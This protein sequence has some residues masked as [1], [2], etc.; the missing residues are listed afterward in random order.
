MKNL[1]LKSALVLSSLLCMFNTASASHLVGG[2]IGYEY[3]GDAGGGMYSYVITLTVYNDCSPASNIPLPD[4][5]QSIAIY[6]HD[7]NGSP[8]GGGDKALFS[9]IVLSLVDSNRVLP[10]TVSGC[11]VGNTEC[12]YKGVYRDTILLPLNFNGYHIYFDDFARTGGIANLQN[13]GGTGMAFHCYIPSNLVDNSSAFFN[14]D[15][16]AFFCAGDTVSILNTATDPDGDLL[17]FSFTDPFAGMSGFGAAPDPLPWTINPVTWLNG[18]Y[19]AN[20]PF[21]PGGYAFINGS[22]GLT[23]YSV[24]TA[25]H[26]VVAVEVREFRN[27]NLIGVTRRDLQLLVINCPPND[28]PQLDPAGSNATLYTVE[29]GDNI[30]FDLDFNDINGDSLTLEASG[31]VF[32]PAFVNPIATINTPVLG[33][34]L[35]STQF[36]WQTACGQAQPLPYFF[37]VSVTDNGCPPKTVNE[38]YEITVTAPTAPTTIFGPLQV[39]ENDMVSYTTDTITGSTYNWTVTGGTITSGQGSVGIDVT[40]GPGGPGLVEVNAISQFGCASSSISLNVTILANPLAAAGNDTVICLGDS[41][42]LGGSPTGPLGATYTWTPA[43]TLDDASLANPWATPTVTTTY[44]VAVTVGGQCTGTDTVVV[45]VGAT[46]YEAGNDTTICFG[47]S[48]QLNA[49]GGGTYVWTP[50]GT[51]SDGSIGNPVATPLDTTL[52]TV[53][54]TDT[55]GCVGT[56]SVTVNVVQLPPAEAGNDT[57]IC[58][59]DGLLIGGSP[60]TTPG[61]SILWSPN[62]NIS[63]IIA[64]NPIVFAQTSP[65]VYTVTITTPEGCVSTDNI[66]IMINPLPTAD[67]G[68]A[69]PICVGDSVQLTASGGTMYS[70]APITGLSNPNIANPMA[71][72]PSTT[73]YVVTVTDANG[74]SST[75]NVLVSVNT[76]S[77]VDA[78]ADVAICINDTVP[79]GGA[80]TGPVGAT[81]SWSP[82]G[83]LNDPSLA[84][85]LANPTVTTQYF[86]TVT[87]ANTCVNIDSITI[88]VNAL[89]VVDA[90]NDVT[91]CAT[92]T[93]VLGGAPTGPAGSGYFWSPSMNLSG[94]ALSNPSAWP[95]TSPFDYVVRVTD[96]NGCVNFDTITI[97]LNT[98]P[99]ADAGTDATICVNDSTQ[100]LATG[101]TTYSWSPTAGLSNPN[102]ADPMASPA[103][104]TSYIVTVTDGNSC[105]QMDTVIVTV[106]PLP[107]VDAGADVAI[108]INDTVPLGGAPTG[109]AGSTFSW[110]PTTALDDPNIANP[111]ANPTVTTQYFVTVTDANS[112]VN[113]DSITITVNPL[114]IVDAGLDQVICFGDTVAIGGAPTGPAG[115]GYFWSPSINISGN[116]ISNPSV[117]PPSS[118]F[119]Y[120]VRVTDPN[121]CVNFDTVTITLN[122]LPIA[123]AGTDA[124]ICINDSTQLLATGGTT[125]SWTPA[126]GLSNP[127]VADPMA[128]PATTTSYIVTVTDGNNCSQMDTVIVTV[129][130]LPVV[131]AGTDAPICIND[132]IQLGGAPTGPAGSTFSWSPT[133]ALDDPNIAN[134]MANPTVT[135]QYF[136]TV[137]DANSCVNIDSITITVNPLPAADAGLDQI[138]CFNDTVAIGGAPT[139]DPT[140]TVLWDNAGSLVD[141]ATDFNPLANP[142]A[143]TQYIV[144]VTDVNG[145]VQTDTMVVT[146]NPLPIVDITQ[147]P[148]IDLCFEDTIQ[149]TA[150]GAV[151]Y[152]WTPALGLSDP[153]I[154][155]PLAFPID[156]TT[157]IVTGIDINGCVNMDTI[158]I[159][160]LD[161][162]T[163]SAGADVYLCIGFDTQLQATGGTGYVWT[164]GATLDDAN[165]ANPLASPLDT[166][167]YVVVVTDANGCVNTD[168]VTVIV[169][170]NPPID[171]GPDVA[172]CNGDSVLLGGNPSSVPGTVFTWMP[173]ADLDDPTLAN[174][175]AFPSVTTT[176]IVMAQNDTCT[177]FDTVIV[178]VN[179]LPPASAGPDA[180]FCIGDSAQL[181]A[182]GGVTFVWTP[183][184]GLSDDS[185]ANPMA[186]PADTTQYIVT[187]TD[188]VGCIGTDTMVLTMNPL[189]VVDAGPDVQVCITDSVQLNATGGDIYVW[190]PATGLDDP[191]VADP[192][193]SPADT[194]QYM[195]MVTDSNSCVNIDSMTVTVNPFPVVDAGPSVQICIGETTPLL[196]TGGDIYVWTPATGLTDPNIAN[197]DATPTDTIT[198]VVTVTDSNSCVNTDSLVVTVNPLPNAS[199]GPDAAI[200]IGDDAQLNA[201]GG[202]TYSWTP[203]ADLTD[204]N[205][206]DPIANPTVTTNYIVSVTDSNSCVQTD[207]MT[208][209]VNNL[210]NIDAG[211]D[212]DLCRGDSAQLMATGGVGYIWTPTIGMNDPNL[213]NPMVAPDTTQMYFVVSSDINGCSNIDSVTVNVF[214]MIA[215][216][217]TSVCFRDSAQLFAAGAGGLGGTTFLWSP[218]T[219]LDD[220]TSATPM[221]SPANTTLYTVTATDANG[222]TDQ[223]TV[224][225]IVID[226]PTADFLVDAEPDCDGMRLTITNNSINASSYAWT[227]G[228][229][230]SSTEENPVTVI[231]FSLNYTVVLTAFNSAGCQDT[232]TFTNSTLTFDDYFDIVVP[233]VF[234]P[235]GD[236]VNDIFE[237][238]VGSIL[239]ECTDIEIFNRWGQTVFVSSGNNILWDGYTPDGV[240]VPTGTYFFTMII[241]GIEYKGSISV[242]R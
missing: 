38:V 122:P 127:N 226:L 199:A 56:D 18:T 92:D 55:I 211:P 103:T 228:N 37:T 214:R 54:V 87:D 161:T 66:T 62:A 136:V 206:A 184:L 61:N 46:T 94:N 35:V 16:V 183:D 110:S 157:Y 48:A 125:Y 195:V 6:G 2:N 76:L 203:A 192:M 51:L 175:N 68:S 240:Q 144:T 182:S 180:Q 154:A 204:A 31:I 233:N 178:T 116:A 202:D 142:T 155:N 33:D 5:T 176:Y 42:Q 141:P 172:I 128:S 96:P 220:P 25:G 115:S 52:Y 188:A 130:P 215:G 12:I 19:N 21:G 27:G 208:L 232:A 151:T 200:C 50:A 120:I 84:N 168:S 49:S 146:V 95:S 148:A 97:S 147:G 39:C 119:D 197:P 91:I 123:D 212:V 210:P 173:A 53:T 132:T 9:E 143:T 74:C 34:S 32:D 102:V 160:V 88:T 105:S 90:G 81:Y 185:I 118:P 78:G 179:Q 163:V 101:G 229:G 131:D 235:N 67:A 69:T 1:L 73:N 75:D 57:T 170:D 126:A 138:I 153:S 166:T 59:G 156:T 13:P 225:V 100:L 99:I 58:A 107:V 218:A 150:T 241:N 36:C 65:T 238:N 137:T 129:N 86:V 224:E 121:G 158:T 29:E 205:I 139:A 124:T 93:T 7:L 106:N 3:L 82:A 239:S 79:L 187:V 194:T 223:L 17:V 135:T 134:P 149:L 236:G 60:T 47:T 152:S 177:S 234:T 8:M 169:N 227:F 207:T 186:S 109:P 20:Q 209:V 230:E 145:C 28:A 89:P 72:P 77:V 112:C 133:T 242:M 44:I 111:L 85:P 43:A 114:P 216:G 71:S 104:T 174:P 219:G 15:P 222:C 167:V 196:A 98:L 63:S 14:D 26:Y 217:D 171:A 231:P 30:C 189:P 80:P 213:A 108:C 198:Y 64:P 237:I 24:P 190:T 181:V 83:T 45:Q 165:I 113:I 140:S 117:S 11:T 4:A 164:P 23:Q 40:W 191:N 41:A 201:T 159:N 162:P 10:P 221:A 193:S 22:T 70:W